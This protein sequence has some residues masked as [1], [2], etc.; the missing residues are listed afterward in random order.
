MQAGSDCRMLGEAAWMMKAWGNDTRRRSEE[1]AEYICGR[2]HG[3]KVQKNRHAPVC[4][5]AAASIELG[6]GDSSCS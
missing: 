3:G 5:A 2:H 4:Q 1:A 6:N